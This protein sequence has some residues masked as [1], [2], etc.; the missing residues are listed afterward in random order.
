MTRVF[1]CDDSPELRLL[2]RTMLEADG[3]I[4]VGARPPTASD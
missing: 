3:D 1:I 2:L 4:A